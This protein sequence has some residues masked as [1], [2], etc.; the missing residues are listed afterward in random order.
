MLTTW[1]LGKVATPE[2]IPMEIPSRDLSVDSGR[3]SPQRSNPGAVRPDP[4][5]NVLLVIVGQFRGP[6]V[7]RR[8]L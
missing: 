5:P 7:I 4:L 1:T 8:N 2:S 3:G 6:E